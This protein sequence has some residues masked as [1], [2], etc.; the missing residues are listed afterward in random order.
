MDVLSA[1]VKTAMNTS[2][3]LVATILTLV[4]GALALTGTATQGRVGRSRALYDEQKDHFRYT[5]SRF[6]YSRERTDWEL[7]RY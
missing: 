3:N 7:L 2:G 4:L 5:V 1:G 6:S